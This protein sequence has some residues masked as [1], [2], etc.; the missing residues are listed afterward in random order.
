MVLQP[1]VTLAAAQVVVQ[2][3]V[4]QRLVVRQQVVLRRVE[5]ALKGITATAMTAMETTLRIPVAQTMVM[6]PTMMVSQA[7]DNALLLTTAK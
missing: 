2:L 1:V 6:E 7:T 4:E 5:N 3:Q